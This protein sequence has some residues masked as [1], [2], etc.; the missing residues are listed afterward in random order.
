MKRTSQDYDNWN[1]EKQALHFWEHDEFYV[2]PRE[3]RFTKMGINIG[4]EECGK[5]EFRRPVLVIKKVWNLFFTVA[6]T[7]K[8]KTNHPFYH[9]VVQAEFNENNQSNK[10]NAYIIL[11]QVKVMDKKRFT[12]K[13]GIVN[14]E[15]FSDIKKKLKTMLF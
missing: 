1:Y 14:Q 11:S 10:D 15:E 7:T 13:M 12:E 4:Y 5:K 8:W 6:M 9:K 2:N 3:I